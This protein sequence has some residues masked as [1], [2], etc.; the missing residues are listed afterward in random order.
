VAAPRIGQ[1]LRLFLHSQCA[2]VV[3]AATAAALLAVT[4]TSVP[5]YRWLFHYWR[6]Y[7]GVAVRDGAGLD[8]LKMY[9]LFPAGLF[10]VPT[11]LMG[12]SFTV[13]QRA[14]QDDDKSSGWKVGLLQCSNIIGCVAGS[15]VVGLALLGKVGTMGTMRV[16]VGGGVTFAVVGACHFGWRST[17]GC[18]AV[19]MMLLAAAV[20][21]NER[22][23]CRMHGLEPATQPV[24]MIAE[25]S[26]GVAA[27]TPEPNG[28]L[29]LS[30]DGKGHSWLPYGSIHSLLGALPAVVHPDPQ[31]VAI[32]GLGSGDTAWAAACR[33]ETREVTVFELCAGEQ[34]LLRRL[35]G[36][37][38]NLQSFL[39]DPRVQIVVADGRHALTR[40][41][42]RF[43]LI[44]ADASRPD[45][46]YSGNL[47]SVEF[48]RLC[49]RRLAPGGV[50]CTWSP[51]PRVYRTFCKA[52]RHVLDI[53]QGELLL[54]GN[55]AL[56]I[57]VPEWE[58]RLF[59]PPVSSYLGHAVV[60]T[61]WTS[62]KSA[63][64]ADPRSRPGVDINTDLVPRD[65]FQ[66]PTRM[67]L[68]YRG[69]G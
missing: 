40:S 27:I 1:P 63:R 53:N 38:P 3:Y 13:L 25:D 46:G 18:L 21:S 68:Q 60:D 23:W 55:D 12:L 37:L 8:L 54:G 15:L 19:G 14:V 44:E 56:N 45:T 33:R 9:V 51:T 35:A 17:F 4:P 32:I 22:L 69:S 65:E 6:G 59:L 11:V 49:A 36:R 28:T 42:K 26:T 29:R 39:R 67:S 30:V 61:V 2:I 62:L 50:M 34:L 24:A 7:D 43:D 16:I 41:P 47:Y 66:S 31:Q 57:D 48:F 52:F 20:P 64:P 58:R 10:A 5:G